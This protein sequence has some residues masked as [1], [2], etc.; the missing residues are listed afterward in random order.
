MDAQELKEKAKK[1]GLDGNSFESVKSAYKSAI[2]ESN[3]SDLIV[4]GGSTFVVAEV[5]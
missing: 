4:V 3:T 5:I 2:E 1:F